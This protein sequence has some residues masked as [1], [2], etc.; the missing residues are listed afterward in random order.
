MSYTIYIREQITP[1]TRTVPGPRGITRTIPNYGSG[2]VFF[3]A[4]S[5]VYSPPD[6][7]IYSD[8]PAKRQILLR[9][10]GGTATSAEIFAAFPLIRAGKEQEIRAEASRLMRGMAEPYSK[11]EQETWLLQANQANAWLENNAVECQTI[12]GMAAERGVPMAEMVMKILGNANAF[13]PYLGYVLGYQQK[14]LDRIYAATDYDE[15]EA[16]TW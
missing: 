13:E 16:I 1:R 7:D 5:L 9:D 15:M 3:D 10:S 4:A 11:E 12:R 6:L 8:D 2:D 14:L